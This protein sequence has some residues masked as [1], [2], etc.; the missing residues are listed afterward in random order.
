MKPAKELRIENREIL[1]FDDLLSKRDHKLLA[2]SL[3][4]LPYRRTQSDTNVSTITYQYYVAHLALEAAKNQH[5]VRE[6]V[7]VA[8]SSFPN[9]KL[10]LREVYI[11]R[12]TY[13]DM[14]FPHRDCTPREDD[15]TAVYFAHERWD[16][17][18]GGET[19][20]FDDTLE[21]L[22]CISA[23][24][25]R[26]VLFRGAVFHKIGIPTR[27]CTESRFSVALKLDSRRRKRP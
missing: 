12:N 23:R 13:G 19:I 6:V 26:L 21:A 15:V 5:L 17:D 20:F 27:Q 24:P 18:W 16:N 14:S 8:E 7:R 9:D 2:K 25:R 4:T 22:A 3:D 1:V 10:I 11:N